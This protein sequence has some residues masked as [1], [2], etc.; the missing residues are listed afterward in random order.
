MQTLRKIEN[1][2]AKASNR[3]NFWQKFLAK[4]QQILAKKLDR[5]VTNIT[6]EK[7]NTL[8]FFRRIKF[9]RLRKVLG[10]LY[11]AHTEK[12]QKEAKQRK[13]RVAFLVNSK[14]KWHGKFLYNLLAESDNLEPIIL[15]APE[16][17]NS[18]AYELNE[19]LSFFKNAGFHTEC[20]YDIAAKKYLDLKIFRPDIVFYEQPWNIESEHSI[21]RVAKFALTCYSPYCFHLL[22]SEYDYLE[23][24]HRFLWKYFV[25]SPLHLESYKSRFNA[26]NC[27]SVG[28]LH[29]DGYLS[30]EEPD[31]KL[32]QDK[33]SGKK[34]IIYAPHFSTDANH[35]MATFHKNRHFILNLASM[36]P[37]TTWIVRP[38]PYFAEQIVGCGVMTKQ[39][40][41]DYWAEWKE[42]GMIS[43]EENFIDLFRTSDCLI[44]DCIS[45]LA[46]YFPTGKPVFHLRSDAQ[47]RKFTNFAEDIIGTYYQIYSN[48]ELDKLFLRVIIEGDDYMAPRRLSRIKAMELPGKEMASQ[49]LFNHIKAELKIQ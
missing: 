19:L 49:R 35:M 17:K 43:L 27:V 10:K 8:S 41:E 1:V 21:F 28:S 5:I 48:A 2:I 31:G 3:G 38:H 32:W 26:S 16:L 33:S 30:S 14:C 15:V 18:G 34:R 29:L 39:E 36:Y 45:F 46:D 24:F 25:E 12:L 4:V 11:A 13:I 23:K 22:C 42:Y 9:A 37:E 47:T 6:F 44:T 40:L 7:I 20:T